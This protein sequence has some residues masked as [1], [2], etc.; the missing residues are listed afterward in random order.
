M[1]CSHFLHPMFFLF[2]PLPILLLLH[3]P[4]C[5]DALLGLLTPSPPLCPHCSR[6][7]SLLLSCVLLLSLFLSISLPFF[8]LCFPFH[9]LISLIVILYLCS[10]FFFLYSYCFVFSFLILPSLSCTSIAWIPVPQSSKSFPHLL[11]PLLFDC[12]MQR[13]LYLVHSSHGW[14]SSD[15]DRFGSIS[16]SET[17]V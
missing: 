10:I 7:I 1:T 3:S 4:A 12:P 13:L 15:L 2:S 9:H 14:F 5:P 6:L 8:S 11:L 16:P 17:R